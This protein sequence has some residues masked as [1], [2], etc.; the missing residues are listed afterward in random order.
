MIRIVF[1]FVLTMNMSGVCAQTITLGKRNSSI[2]VI[3]SSDYRRINEPFIAAGNKSI[4]GQGL[5]GK[6]AEASRLMAQATLG[7]KLEDISAA[8]EMGLE[9]WIDDQLSHSPTL[10]LPEVNAIFDELVAR[11][12]ANGGDS[13]DV[14]ARPYGNLFTYA[15]WH[16]NMTDKQNALRQRVAL[17]LSEILVISTNSDLDGYGDGL[18][19]YYDILLRN[20]FTNYENILQEVTLHPCMGIYLSHYNNPKAD[21]LANTHP[22][23]NFA[24]EVMQLF[25]IGLYELNLDGSRKIDE[26]GKFIPTYGQPEIKE[27]AKVFTGLG[28]SEFLP[29]MFEQPFPEFGDGIYG[30]VMTQPMKMYEEWHDVQ[31]KT[32]LNNVV[33]PPNQTGLEDIN[34]GINNLFNHPNVGPFICKQLIQ[35]LVRSNPSPEYIAR[36][37]NIFNDN[38]GGVRGDMKAVIKALLLDDEAR[39]CESLSDPSAG[40]LLEPIHRYMQFAKS[41]NIE[42]YYDRYWNI[43]YDFKQATGQSPLASP[44]VFNFFLPSYQ[45]IGA[46]SEQN[47]IG[48]EFQI[49][50]TRTSVGYINEVNS[51]AIYNYV[52]TNWEENEPSAWLNTDQLNFLAK[53]TETLINQLDLIFTQGNL[54]LRTRRIIKMALEPIQ[55]ANYPEDRVRL[56]IYLIMISPDYAI[57][58]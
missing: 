5:T 12:F 3:S 45:P 58:K 47:L 10:L 38:G 52:L 29:N 25:S 2:D 55:E 26:N 44:S 39:S 54:S 19:D 28:P 21:E 51:W 46:L 41:L 23:E 7:A 9:A 42:Q 11:H 33:L 37:S 22:D 40:K 13:I 14:S 35:K 53:D 6:M 56:A 43:G 8:A 30:I 31:E 34:A 15:W 48:P 50:N 49:H 18:S 27:F 20:A 24:R 17:A 1:L 16:V 57:L 36:V 4:N 32:L